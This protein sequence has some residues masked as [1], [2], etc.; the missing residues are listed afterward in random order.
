MRNLAE[1]V[2]IPLS[3][4][5]SLILHHIVFL[6]LYRQPPSE[7]EVVAV[8]VGS[9]KVKPRKE[10]KVRRSPSFSREE[11]VRLGRKVMRG[12]LGSF[13]SLSI[14]Y[15]NLKLYLRQMY[16]LGAKTL[17]YDRR[18]GEILGEVDIFSS[19]ISNLANLDKFSPIKRVIE[20]RMVEGLKERIA[21]R[22]GAS[23]DDYEVWLLV[24]KDLE[25]R[26]LGYQLQVF[27]H[28]GL[29]FK[30][31]SKVEGFFDG[32]LRIKRI[33]L[34]DGRVMDVPEVGA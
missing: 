13:P 1:V 11:L 18:L 6:S 21:E 19:K 15:P 2:L 3:I 34:K 17:I 14:S 8:K 10:A 9:I 23:P 16:S 7:K 24:P 28:Y 31:V 5:I 12:D 4:L 29:S 22:S 33:R 32:R 30:D 27:R 20:D 26:W 25:A